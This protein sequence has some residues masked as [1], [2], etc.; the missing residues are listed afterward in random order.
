MK[1]DTCILFR[2]LYYRR[3]EY[4]DFNKINSPQYHMGL[5]IPISIKND[6]SKKQKRNEIR[7]WISIWFFCFYVFRL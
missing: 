6:N 4:K 1:K 2:K 5:R 7:T 3:S